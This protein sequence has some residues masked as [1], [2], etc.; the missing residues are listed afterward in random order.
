MSSK[1]RGG[2]SAA[3]FHRLCDGRILAQVDDTKF[4]VA[5][6][7]IDLAGRVGRIAFRQHEVSIASFAATRNSTRLARWAA[8][9]EHH[10]LQMAQA[11]HPANERTFAVEKRRIS[12]SETPGKLDDLSLANEVPRPLSTPASAAGMPAFKEIVGIDMQ[13]PSPTVVVVSSIF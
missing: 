3:S 12:A 9:F 7:R 11:R 8:A 10:S 6:E 1:R 13:G 4:V 2:Y 5:S